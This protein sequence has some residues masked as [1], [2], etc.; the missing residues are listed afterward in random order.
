MTNSK[1]SRT[2]NMGQPQWTVLPAATGLSL[3]ACALLLAACSGGGSKGDAIVVS[4][5]CSIDRPAPDFQASA[6]KGFNV[7]GWAFEKGAAEA[8][9][10]TQVQFASVD[11]KDF[12]VVDAEAGKPRPDVA[13]ALNAPG[14]AN[15]GYEAVVAADLLPANNYAITIIQRYPGYSVACNIARVLAVK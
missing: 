6:G 1:N 11:L 3:L 14:A 4:N 12:K 10:K 5:Q 8:P 7:S 2:M 15:A 13:Q 9:T